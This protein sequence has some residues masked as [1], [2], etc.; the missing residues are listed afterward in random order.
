V[1]NTFRKHVAAAGL[2]R[3]DGEKKITPHSM[4]HYFGTKM[5]DETGDLALVQDL[6]GHASP[7]TTRVYTEVAMTK[8]KR[9]HRKVF[10]ES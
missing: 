9:A 2:H 7:Q 10:G 1:Q 5:L 8:K 4:R 3:Q 6:L